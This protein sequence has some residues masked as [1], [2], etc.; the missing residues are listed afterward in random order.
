M[1]HG[2][3]RERL[4]RRSAMLCKDLLFQRT[5]VDAN[6]DRDALRPT[7]ICNRLY[8]LVGANIARINADFIH[9]RLHAGKRNAII[10]MDIRHNRHG[11][12]LF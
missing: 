12:C 3:L 4:R 11:H 9:P 10:K 5:A 6:A 8:P 7:G 1:I 2:A